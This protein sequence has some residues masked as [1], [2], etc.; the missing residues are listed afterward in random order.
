MHHMDYRRK[1]GFIIFGIA[2]ALMLTLAYIHLDARE[3]PQHH[4]ENQGTPSGSQPHENQVL[5]TALAVRDYS[6]TTNKTVY[7][8]R[9]VMLAEITVD[10]ETGGNAQI[11]LHGIYARNREHLSI[12]QNHTLQ[13]GENIIRLSHRLPSCTGCAGISPGDYVITAE[14]T[15]EETVY[16]ANTTIGIRQ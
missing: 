3:T 4:A 11:W 13:K 15:I 6:L 5:E 10:S 8:S 14:L 12:R 7:R 2:F 16:E 9:Q 1:P